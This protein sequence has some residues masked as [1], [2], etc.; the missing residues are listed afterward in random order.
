MCLFCLNKTFVKE[1]SNASNRLTFDMD[2]FDGYHW[3]FQEFL[4]LKK[5]KILA[6]LLFMENWHFHFEDSVI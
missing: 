5:S 4:E 1:N 3:N 6:I 2:K